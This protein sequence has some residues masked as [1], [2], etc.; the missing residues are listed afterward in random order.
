MEFEIWSNKK[1]EQENFAK[2][3]EGKKAAQ[4][5]A[6][7]Y[8]APYYGA[9]DAAKFGVEPTQPIKS[10]PEIKT[11]PA[12][13][14]GGITLHPGMGEVDQKAKE[15]AAAKEI[16]SER[17]RQ[18]QVKAPIT[19]IGQAAR[20]GETN[21][22]TKPFTFWDSP[23]AEIPANRFSAKGSTLPGF[24][25]RTGMSPSSTS[26]VGTSYDNPLE[27]TPFGAYTHNWNIEEAAPR[28]HR[29]L[30]P[31]MTRRCRSLSQNTATK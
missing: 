26:T 12:S 9:G 17:E 23:K 11:T 30:P 29:F 14:R 21:A 6:A 10:Q 3:A 7:S 25:A 15:S 13:R 2:W 8:S 24:E 28:S 5:I 16:T 20:Q 22:P 1:K 4:P 18:P 27:A 19:P 31:W